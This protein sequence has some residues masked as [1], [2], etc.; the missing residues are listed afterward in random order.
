VARRG[1]GAF[2]KRR[3]ENQVAY[4]DKDMA[5][6]ISKL[7]R[8]QVDVTKLENLA[9]KNKVAKLAM[10]I[11]PKLRDVEMPIR[12][13]KESLKALKDAVKNAR[14]VRKEVTEGRAAAMKAEIA[15][16]ATERIARLADAD[17]QKLQS[18]ITQL[19]GIVKTAYQ[20]CKS[21]LED[22]ARFASGN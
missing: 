5:T 19:R 8:F 4:S 2:F 20:D 21:G 12:K 22:L 10:A 13:Y 16:K 14:A 17:S 3:K 18:T 9:T 6:L 1:A 11:A 15:E 7:E